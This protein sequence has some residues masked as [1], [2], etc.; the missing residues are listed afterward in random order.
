M[1]VRVGGVEFQFTVKGVAQ[2]TSAFSKLG[3]ASKALENRVRTTKTLFGG[4]SKSL[5]S[6]STAVAGFSAALGGTRILQ[7][8]KDA[9]LLA[10]RVENLG[11][12]LD[13]VGRISGIN[14]AQIR[15]VED[16]VKRLGITTRSA[17]QSLS[18]LAQAN[19]DLTKATQ[20]TRIAQDA[21]VIAGIDSSEAFNRLVVSIQR[22]DVRLLRNLGIVINLNQVYNQ[23]AQ[24]TGR[25]AASLTAFE[26]RQLVLNEVVARGAQITGTYEAALQDSFKQFTSL[27]RLTEEAVRTFGEQFI[28]VFEKV[29]KVTGDWLKAFVAGQ[30]A[31]GPRFLANVAAASA[32][33]AAFTVVVG[34]LAA[35]FAAVSIAGGPLTLVLLGLGALIA[36]GV[37][38]WTNYQLE[39]LEAEK[40]LKDVEEQ[41]DQTAQALFEANRSLETIRNL[42]RPL[43]GLSADEVRTLREEAAKLAVLFPKLADEINAAAELESPRELIRVFE[44]FLPEALQTAEQNIER[45][46]KQRV[47]SEA[48]FREALIKTRLAE[49]GLTEERIKEIRENQRIQQ[50]GLDGIA[51]VNRE[52]IALSQAQAD[53]QAQVNKELSNG[54][55]EF[56][57]LNPLLVQNN[58]ELRKFGDNLLEAERA[59]TQLRQARLTA[60]FA[61][62]EKG[63]KELEQAGNQANQIVSKL[64]SQRNRI[65]KRTN[66][67]IVRD[68]ENASNQLI[69]VEFETEE[70]IQN[71]RRAFEQAQTQEAETIR[72][73]RLAEIEREAR[74]TVG[75]EKELADERTKVLRQFAKTQQRIAAQGRALEE[76]GIQS[77]TDS[78][79][80][81]TLASENATLQLEKQEEATRRLL[82]QARLEADGIGPRLVRLRQRFNEQSERL[83]KTNEELTKS[84]FTS[85]EAIE[86]QSGITFDIIQKVIAGSIDPKIL[87]PKT[88]ELVKRFGIV[89]RAIENNRKE[90]LARE[91]VFNQ[92]FE[93]ERK[94]LSD[95]L[96]NEQKRLNRELLKI[97]DPRAF[98]ESTVEGLR[99]ITDTFKQGAEETKDFIRDQEGE[100]LELGRID[101][102]IQNQILGRQFKT[103][104]DFDRAL[105]RLRTGAV[106]NI[107]KIRDEFE[108]FR[109]AARK[110]T[111]ATDL[112]RINEIFSVRLADRIRESQFELK[113]LETQLR[114]FQKISRPKQERDNRIENQRLFNELVD[115][116]VPIFKARQ[117]IQRREIEQR[118]ELNTQ[119]DELQ[120]K[121]KEA[122]N[123]QRQLV[124]ERT[125]LEQQF[126]AV[127]AAQ[128]KEIER[129]VGL[130]QKL[131]E[132]QKQEIANIQQQLVKNKQAQQTLN[133]FAKGQT[134]GGGTAPAAPG[135]PTPPAPGGTPNQPSATLANNT[136]KLSAEARALA[137]ATQK[138]VAVTEKALNTTTSVLTSIRENA[139]KRILAQEKWIAERTAELEAG[140]QKMR[141]AN[142]V[143]TKR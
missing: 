27:R 67:E 64:Q 35:A 51:V 20:L 48:R 18:Q 139:D 137:L 17:R 131:V 105:A 62:F 86:K 135:A 56:I 100:L 49:R 8:A 116:G 126:Q 1:A 57:K 95:R 28:P 3:A 87:N 74:A 108:K 118:K 70:Q 16:S 54:S 119:E 24:Q 104:Q 4:L 45:F 78:T 59:I 107:T 43:G 103:L 143:R 127:V 44:T 90:L 15:N 122:R 85:L 75:K 77:L 132:L 14:S 55:D 69:A 110:A 60:T 84:F 111:T 88:R 99:S 32:A 138:D 112:N 80:A 33:L 142:L 129:Q 29:V 130:R 41:A 25:T 117:E 66:L 46:E 141:Q 65:F 79:K 124:A 6:V 22:N 123:A 34:G 93:R 96:I 109:D 31:I 13:N 134:P 7:F 21:A 82:E 72:D 52:V 30:T 106:P 10:A 12:V 61:E 53:V 136:A 38:L 94:R 113:R 36:G 19:I 140:R 40:R 76:S 115:Q 97:Q 50:Q 2:S 23:F 120:R 128:T 9:T 121:V 68:F 39:V 89:Q 71:A 42:D 98:R 91:K 63:L 102:R 101:G 37:A 11:T 5:G 125:A 47:E 92:E 133:Q 114:E 58:E 26:K 83:T 81:L 73:R